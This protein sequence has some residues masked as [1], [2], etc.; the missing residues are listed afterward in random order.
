MQPDPSFWQWITEHLW[1]PLMGLVAVWWSMLQTRIRRTERKADSAI[2]R[3]E[4]AEHVSR[5]EARLGELR[6]DIVKIF[7]LFR[8]HDRDDRI[9]HDQLTELIHQNHKEV[10]NLLLKDKG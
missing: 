2:G 6:F 4:F 9:R 10:L 5:T 1:V 8:D 3:E 7:D